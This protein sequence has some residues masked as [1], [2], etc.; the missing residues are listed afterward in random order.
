MNR[1]VM[2]GDFIAEGMRYCVVC[3]DYHFRNQ[4]MVY[5][6]NCNICNKP[7]LDTSKI[8][9]CEDSHDTDKPE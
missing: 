7:K 3:E 8:C 1:C 6:E 2:C 4:K 5:D 9:T